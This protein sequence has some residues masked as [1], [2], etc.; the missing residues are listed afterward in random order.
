MNST[1]LRDAYSAERPRFARVA[2]TV[3][4]SLKSA[5]QSAGLTHVVVSSR[6]KE[7]QSL[8]RKAL[9][10]RYLDPLQDILDK[11]GVRAVIQYRQHEGAIEALVRERFSVLD[12]VDKRSE[13]SDDQ[14]GYMGLHLVVTP[15]RGDSVGVPC[16]I[17]VRTAAEDAWATMSHSML[18]KAP[19]VLEGSEKRRLFRL[20]ALSEIFDQQADSAW[21]S[22]LSAPGY[23]AGKAM[24][25]LEREFFRL[26]GRLVVDGLSS[27]VIRTVLLPGYTI[28]ELASIDGVI[29]GHVTSNADKTSQR[30]RPLSRR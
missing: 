24:E 17:Q 28:E 11:A 3:E 27:E 13:L 29:A 22:F 6:V 15:K 19:D 7:V 14:L 10:K 30:V 2:K 23:V 9:L 26:T 8:V 25:S 4:R 12:R 21:T 1:E 20:S 18:Y 5:V 16:E